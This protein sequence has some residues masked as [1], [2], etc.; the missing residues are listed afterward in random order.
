[1]SPRQLM[2]EQIK[3]FRKF[4]GW[5]QRRLARELGCAAR[6]I[7]EW[8]GGRRGPPA[9]LGLALLHLVGEE[10]RWEWLVF[11]DLVPEKIAA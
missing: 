4:M 2:P 6:T 5:P 11:S 9:M 1:M 7:E 3:A 8:E 10:R